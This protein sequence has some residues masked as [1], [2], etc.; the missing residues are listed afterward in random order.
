MSID[1]YFELEKVTLRTE[2]SFWDDQIEVH[3]DT[4]WF[5]EEIRTEQDKVRKMLELC[6]L[7]GEFLPT[8]LERSIADAIEGAINKRTSSLPPASSMGQAVEV[9]LTREGP[10]RYAQIKKAVEVEFPH[11]EFRL[12]DVDKSLGAALSYAVKKG[13]IER[14]SRGIYRVKPENPSAKK[15]GENEPD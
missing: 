10:M 7:M 1:S 14:V 13:K 4:P 12:S 6:E 11:L 3:A 5:A 2:I 9:I 15:G 8:I